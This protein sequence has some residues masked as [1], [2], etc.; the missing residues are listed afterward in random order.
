MTLLSGEPMSEEAVG[1]LSN[2]A[3]AHIGD[4]VYELL[5][6]TDLCR[7]GDLTAGALHRDTVRRVSA[8]AQAKAAHRLLPLLTEEESEIYRRARNTRVSAVPQGCSPGEYHAATALE[9]LFGWLYLRGQADR[10]ARLFAA[11]CGEES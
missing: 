3:L 4:G 2:L 9:A 5:V 7:S 10:I 11:A 8:V 1:R 6:R